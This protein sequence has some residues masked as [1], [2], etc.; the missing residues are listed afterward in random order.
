MIKGNLLPSNASCS[1]VHY[2]SVAGTRPARKE[3]GPKI[4][5]IGDKSDGHTSRT[6]HGVCLLLWSFQRGKVPY[7][8]PGIERSRRTPCAVV[9]NSVGVGTG[10][11]LG[12]L[13]QNLKTMEN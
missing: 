7:I 9:F 11:G 13:D 1:L 2:L 10:I 6:A 12:L 8:L 4:V 5:F 3:K